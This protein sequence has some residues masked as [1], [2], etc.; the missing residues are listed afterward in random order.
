MSDINSQNQINIIASLKEPSI[1]TKNSLEQ[2]NKY[3]QEIHKNVLK[4]SSPKNE[5]K[6][7]VD[8]KEGNEIKKDNKEDNIIE[9]KKE[10]IESIDEKI[11]EDKKL[12]NKEIEHSIKDSELNDNTDEV[13]KININKIKNS[14]H[15]KVSNDINI[16]NSIGIKKHSIFK[17]KENE[18]ISQKT[19]NDKNNI[20]NDNKK[21]EKKS[22]NKEYVYKEKDEITESSI[23]PEELMT[24]NISQGSELY[25]NDIIAKLGGD[26]NNSI[27]EETL[28]NISK[29]NN[30]ENEN[31]NENNKLNIIKEID[32]DSV[33]IDSKEVIKLGLT[34]IPITDDKDNT[35]LIT[36][37]L[38]KACIRTNDN[39]KSK[40][41]IS[42]IE[43]DLPREDE[44]EESGKEMRKFSKRNTKNSN[45]IN[46]INDKVNNLEIIFNKEESQKDQNVLIEETKK[47][48]YNEINNMYE[49]KLNL[50]KINNKEKY[51]YITKYNDPDKEKFGYESDYF[52]CNKNSK[53]YLNRRNNFLQHKYFSYILSKKEKINNNINN[54]N[55]EK[56]EK[57]KNKNKDKKKDDSI[58]SIDNFEYIPEEI[59]KFKKNYNEKIEPMEFNLNFIRANTPHDNIK[60]YKIND[61]EDMTSFYYYFNLYSPEEDF[62]K[63]LD[64]ETEK[65]IVSCFTTYRKVL[66]DGNS[67]K[68]AFSYL[69]L[70]N[71][72]LQ[73]KVKKLE[74]IIYD[75]KKV[76]GNKFKDI[77][78]ICNILI[79][80]KENSSIDY[81]MNS[82]NNPNYNFDEIMIT[83]IEDTI[84][85]VLGVDSTKRK[86]QEIDFNVLRILANVF[87]V[88]LEIYYIEEDDKNKLLK[89]KKLVILN[90]IFL[91][92]KKN[93]KSSNYN[94]CESSTTFRL[95]FFLNSFYIVYTKKSDID[96]TLANNNTE[97]QYY[98]VSTLPKYKCP[99]CKKCTGLDILPSNEAIFCHICL[100]KYLQIILEKRAILY[101][102]SNFSC[103]EY[104]TRPIKITSDT[105][106]TP[107]LYKYIT[108]NYIINDFEKIV[109]KICFKCFEK[110]EKEKIKKLKCMCQL[111]ENCLEK[112]LKENIKDKVCLNKFELNTLNRTKC[113][114][115]NEVDL[116]NLMELSKNQPTENDKKRAEERLIK[117]LKTRCCLCPEKDK[118]KLLEI[119]IINGPPH[120]VCLKCYDKLSIEDK[121]QNI[122]KNKN[123]INNELQ[124]SDFESNDTAIKEKD[125]DKEKN[126]IKKKFY[127]EICFERHTSIEDNEAEIQHKNIIERVVQYGEGKFKCCKGKCNI[128]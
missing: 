33:K 121:S 41:Y 71:F 27:K 1:G 65:E 78:N 42:N 93:I 119:K 126:I 50:V 4:E 123:E 49:S 16:I 45:N 79:D 51:S 92:A 112:L 69:L 9:E 40:D 89:M 17:K 32:S 23:N 75:I 18:D 67:F 77:K 122:E 94:E 70:E 103:I 25:L 85:N 30:N 99:T 114:C 83:Y 113:L 60:E 106:I 14:N 61:I 80:I 54:E 2:I 124:L 5:I 84:K 91:Q 58:D 15:Y 12:N 55:N 116:I 96:S 120:F 62:K 101:V 48:I 97:K 105:I 53:N 73:N 35:S 52:L 31:E 98:Y 56:K 87:D 64:D 57:I 24:Y 102:K 125:K 46:I 88:N 95:L 28:N 6:S 108:K 68:R 20:I 110:Y 109:E 7:I 66:N 44:K 38:N 19:E 37:E 21:E 72:I 128:Y 29:E 118:F 11:N 115:Q 3:L 82:Y 76:L 81:L 59:N 74:F 13:S 8:E 10:S 47:E 26:E 43:S 22:K 90:D 111:C 63:V 127:C 107:S 100:N 117:K 86:Y 104:Y 36:N 34:N 39:I